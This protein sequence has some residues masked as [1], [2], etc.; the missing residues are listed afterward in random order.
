MV[1]I[2]ELKK[3]GVMGYWSN[4]VME[5]WNGWSNGEMENCPSKTGFS[6]NAQE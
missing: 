1:K 3:D 6:Q 5:E 2:S 4:G